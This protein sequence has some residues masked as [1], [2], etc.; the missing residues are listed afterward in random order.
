MKSFILN[1]LEIIFH[2]LNFFLCN[3]LNPGEEFDL[4]IR[5]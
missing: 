4:K 1:F 3:D 2:T 5:N